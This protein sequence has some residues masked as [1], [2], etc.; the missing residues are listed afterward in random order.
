MNLNILWFK[1]KNRTVLLEHVINTHA[2]Y[3][4]VGI[5]RN[6]IIFKTLITMEKTGFPCVLASL[7]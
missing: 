5:T 2:Y 1:K 4:C 3:L 6:G 7:G